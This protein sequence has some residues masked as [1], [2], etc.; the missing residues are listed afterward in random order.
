MRALAAGIALVLVLLAASVALGTT[1]KGFSFKS[2]GKAVTPG[3]GDTTD[4]TSYEDFPFVIAAGDNNGQMSVEV[5]WT[6][7][8]D[9]FDLVVYKKNSTGG[10]DQVGSSGNAPPQ[11][12]E[13]VIVDAQG[14]KPITPGNYVV[15]VVNYLATNPD[16]EGVVKFTELKVPNKRPTAKLKAPKT[17]TA[18][19]AT[20]L[21]ASGSRDSDGKIVNYRWDLNGDGSME[22]NG[23]TK[24]TL[25]H[26]FTPGVYHVTVRVTDNGGKRAYASRT[27]RV[28]KKKK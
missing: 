23:G 25:S 10:L 27:V 22:T 11:N 19:K 17:V 16:F 20:K 12:N 26:K 24:K 28:K 8:A 1:T 21:D 5:H 9:D 13:Q 15:R 6:N 14:G 7:P 18:P 3:A 2:T 4:P